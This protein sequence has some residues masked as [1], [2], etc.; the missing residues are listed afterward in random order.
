MR[1]RCKDDENTVQNPTGELQPA[2][3]VVVCVELIIGVL[4]APDHEILSGFL[5]RTA[6]LRIPN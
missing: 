4:P 5:Y 3:S 2:A 6:R 1:R